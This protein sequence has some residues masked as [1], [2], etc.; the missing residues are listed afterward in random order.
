MNKIQF[1]FLL[2]VNLDGNHS[3]TSYM[4][5]KKRQ[6]QLNSYFYPHIPH[7]GKYIERELSFLCPWHQTFC[8]PLTS[9]AF[10]YKSNENMSIK[11]QIVSKDLNSLTYWHH[12]LS[13]SKM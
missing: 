7:K 12:F 13:I 10:S 6:C 9:G 11:L 5:G 2:A 1:C 3:F 8:K 4:S